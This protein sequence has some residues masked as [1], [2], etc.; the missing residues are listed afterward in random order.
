MSAIFKYKI[1]VCATGHFFSEIV[2]GIV[3]RKKTRF[4]MVLSC[5]LKAGL[6]ELARNEKKTV[7]DTIIDLVKIGLEHRSESKIALR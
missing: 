2:Q 7:A 3:M 1:C 5:E 6:I 4:N